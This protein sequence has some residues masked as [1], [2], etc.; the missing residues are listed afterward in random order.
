MRFTLIICKRFRDGTTGSETTGKEVKGF[1]NQ[2]FQNSKNEE[3]FIKRSSGKLDS[4]KLEVQSDICKIKKFPGNE[5][6]LKSSRY[7]A[8]FM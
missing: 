8:V 1:R 5:M 3:N 6:V 7:V 4:K 2:V